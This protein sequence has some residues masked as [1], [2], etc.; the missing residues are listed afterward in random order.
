MEL[1]LGHIKYGSFWGLSLELA[2]SRGQPR[3]LGDNTAISVPLKAQGPDKQVC[4]ECTAR[5]GS[6][7]GIPA[8]TSRRWSLFSRSFILWDDLWL[9]CQQ[10]RGFQRRGAATESPICAPTVLAALQHECSQAG[11]RGA[12]RSQA[13]CS[14]HLDN[15]C[16]GKS[17]GLG[18]RRPGC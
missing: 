7:S 3:H 12:R 16:P 14:G 6:C 17:T 1:S 4:K 13:Q 8:P 10:C 9:S 11:H 2:R 18:V 5:Q 15:S